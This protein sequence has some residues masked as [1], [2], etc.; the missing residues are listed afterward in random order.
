MGG[1]MHFTIHYYATLQQPILQPMT[2]SALTL[3]LWQSS[4]MDQQQ[5]QESKLRRDCTTVSPRS[6]G[7]MKVGKK[8][9]KKICNLKAFIGTKRV[10][11]TKGICKMSKLQITF[12]FSSH[13]SVRNVK[14][15]SAQHALA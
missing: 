8:G 14:V 15:M 12:H 13:S 2:S 6:T 4:V 10:K 5:C 11:L 9:R 1:H 3:N 7:V